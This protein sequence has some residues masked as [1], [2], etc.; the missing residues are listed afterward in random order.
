VTVVGASREVIEHAARIHAKQCLSRGVHTTMYP[1]GHTVAIC[2]GTCHRPVYWAMKP[3][4]PWPC[5]HADQLAD[6]S[7]SDW[8]GAT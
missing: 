7:H 4:T 8:W 2:C 1:C 5:P 6:S 3:G